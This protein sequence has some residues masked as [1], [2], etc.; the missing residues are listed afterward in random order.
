MTYDHGSIP[1]LRDRSAPQ[2]I[3]PVLDVFACR[4]WAYKT[5]NRANIPMHANQVHNKKRIADTEICQGVRLRSWFGERRERYWVVVDKNSQRSTDD[6]Q[7][8]SDNKSNANSSS[9]SGSSSSSS[10]SSIDNDNP[11]VQGIEQW[12]HKTQER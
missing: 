6:E 4:E 5:R 1:L 3:L 8:L 11:I 10:Q 12:K 9:S 7:A 2:P